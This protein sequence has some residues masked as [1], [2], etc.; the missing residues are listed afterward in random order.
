MPFDPDNFDQ[1]CP[2][3]DIPLNF[4]DNNDYL[5]DQKN[6]NF[7]SSLLNENLKNNKNNSI[8][9]SLIGEYIF[10]RIMIKL[11]NK[12]I[13]ENLT[14]VSSNTKCLKCNKYWLLRRFSG[15]IEKCIKK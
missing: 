2:L 5:E 10:D 15:H 8:F 3:E 4:S 13:D 6:N 1:T 14:S 9:N 7:L 11:E 12:K